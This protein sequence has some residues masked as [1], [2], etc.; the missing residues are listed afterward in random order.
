MEK[1]LVQVDA[2]T[3]EQIDGYVAVI[4]P[5]RQNGFS[6]E[7]WVAM[8]QKALDVLTQT[9][10]GGE[11]YRVLLAL[12]GQVDWENYICISQCD[13]AERLGIQRTGVTRSI[14]KLVSAGILLPAP[15]VARSNTYRLNPALGW[16]GSAKNHNEALRTRMRELGLSIVEGA[17]RDDRTRDWV[18]E[19][20]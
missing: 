17:V 6:A 1:R 3:G 8:S 19:G 5:R 18:E 4:R 10:L 9:N 15:K 20:A 11:T 2:S 12:L 7:G 16:K 13:V 14:R